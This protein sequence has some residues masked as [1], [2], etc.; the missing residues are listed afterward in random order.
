MSQ[1]G[2]I[3]LKRPQ[4]GQYIVEVDL[5]VALELHFVRLANA[6]ILRRVPRNWVEKPSC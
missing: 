6:S 5:N 1:I 3:T 2:Q 4:K